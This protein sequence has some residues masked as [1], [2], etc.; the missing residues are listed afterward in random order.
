[1]QMRRPAKLLWIAGLLAAS[2]P[3]AAVERKGTTMTIDDETSLLN[4]K[5]L[6]ESLKFAKPMKIVAIHSIEE[7]QNV[8]DA[9][10]FRT[11]TS[12]ILDVCF[13]AV[14][15]FKDYQDR[16]AGDPILRTMTCESRDSIV[17]ALGLAAVFMKGTSYV[18]A[19]TPLPQAQIAAKVIDITSYATSSVALVVSVTKCENKMEEK[20]NALLKACETLNTMGANCVGVDDE[21]F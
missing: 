4:P 5:V 1:M 20:F 6:S 12:A 17:K 8:F 19:F 7:P 21:A 14:G 15:P 3:L 13:S 9:K 2:M 11:D 16:T 10:N 18:C